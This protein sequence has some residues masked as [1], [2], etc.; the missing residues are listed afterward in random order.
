[1]SSS[2]SK[3]SLILPHSNPSPQPQCTSLSMY[4]PT[5]IS[6]TLSLIE[7]C[8][9]SLTNREV[10]QKLTPGQVNLTPNKDKKIREGLKNVKYPQFILFY[11]FA[12]C[13]SVDYDVCGTW[14]GYCCLSTAETE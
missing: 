6:L 10:I 8:S 13:Y 2:S 7:R 11:L 1:M 14:Q 9:I 4:L 5:S 12:S 3:S